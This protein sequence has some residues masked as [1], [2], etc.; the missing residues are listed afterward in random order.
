MKIQVVILAGGMATRL[1]ELTKNRPKSLVAIQGKPFL[2]Y[3]LELLK[4]HEISDIV[5]CIGHLGG[6]IRK[7]FGDGSNYGVHLTYSLEDE[8][9]G[10]A[11]A[12]KNAAPYLN[13]TFLVIYGDSYLLLD[14]M[15]IYAYFLT[16]QKLSLDTVFRNNDAFD[17]SNIVIRD[18]MVEVYSKSEKT[19]DMVYIDCGA[20]IFHKEV[21]QLIP[22]DHF[23]SLE[24]LFL[25]L[26][27]KEQLLAFEVKER[28]YEIGSPQGLKDFEAFIQ[29]RLKK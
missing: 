27:E 12:L 17:A 4:D 14:F 3:Q 6:Q 16:Q 23:Y 18:N 20:V 24:E 28:F 22:E 29:R 13:D 25:R 8:P 5:L 7:A 15:K 2:A 1:G 10:T 21:L 26:I 11:G 9:L 19:P